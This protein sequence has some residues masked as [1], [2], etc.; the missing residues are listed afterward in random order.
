MCLEGPVS[1]VQSDGEGQEPKHASSFPLKP[2]APHPDL[3]STESLATLL[4]SPHPTQEGPDQ[5]QR[6]GCRQQGPYRWD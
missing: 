6:G 5:G 4:D 3:S 2:R 1:A